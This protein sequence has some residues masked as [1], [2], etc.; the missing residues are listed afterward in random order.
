MFV[1]LAGLLE[2]GGRRLYR[3]IGLLSGI[4]PVSV[5]ARSGGRSA[6]G[7]PASAGRAPSLQAAEETIANS[8]RNGERLDERVTEA[9]PSGD[10]SRPSIYADSRPLRSRERDGQLSARI[11]RAGLRAGPH[12]TAGAGL[13][14]GPRPNAVGRLLRAAAR[15]VGP[16]SC[17]PAR[18]RRGR[19]PCR[20]ARTSQEKKGRVTPGP[21]SSIRPPE[22]AGTEAG[23]TA[24]AARGSVAG[25]GARSAAGRRAGSAGTFGEPVPSIVVPPQPG[26]AGLAMKWPHPKVQEPRRATPACSAVKSLHRPGVTGTRRIVELAVD[27][28]R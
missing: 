15:D 26:V 5:R 14:A 13:R 1:V 21:S 7:E 6:G 2:G 16:A 4:S 8:S 28:E 11:R 9:S 3:R 19:P 10:A 22:R 18:E 27:D 24:L 23:P 25:Y 12:A 17:R 20:P